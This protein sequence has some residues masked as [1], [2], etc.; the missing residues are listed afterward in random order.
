M[1]AP[2]VVGKHIEDAQRNDEERAGPFRLESNG[3]QSARSKSDDGD[4]H[5]AEGP[6]PLDDKPEEEEDEQE[7]GRNET[8]QQKE[9]EVEEQ[10]PEI[11]LSPKPQLTLVQSNS[12][13]DLSLSHD[14]SLKLDA[15]MGGEDV[16]DDKK[17]L[18]LDISGLGSD[19]L[20]LGSAHDLS[21]LAA[22]DPL[23][24]GPLMDGSEDPFAGA[25]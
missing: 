2:P 18:E 20:Q 9:V 24:G 5:A 13:L 3:N 15:S 11:V 4:K 22:E 12:E 23:L 1:D 25:S 16:D 14:P 17:A 8:L 6:F 19:G 21:Q 7:E 10:P